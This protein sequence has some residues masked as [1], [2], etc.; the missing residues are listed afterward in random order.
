MTMS[1]LM[2]SSLLA[3]LGAGCSCDRRNDA[4]PPPMQ[5]DSSDIAAGAVLVLGDIEGEVWRVDATGAKHLAVAGNLHRGDL[6]TAGNNGRALVRLSDGRELLIAPGTRLRVGESSKDGVTVELENGTIVS[7][8]PTGRDN[9]SGVSLSVLTPFGITRIPAS[10]GRVDVSLGRESV[11]MT[12]ELGGVTFVDRTGRELLAKAGDRIEVTVGGAQLL[13]A[14]GI[15][16]V[17]TINETNTRLLPD[18]P[19]SDI[20]LPTSRKLRIY[21]DRVGEVTLTWPPA[22]SQAHIEVSR[23]PEG[24]DVIMSGRTRVP[25]VT[26]NAPRGGDLYWRITGGDANKVL[27]GHARFR[28]DRGRSVLDLAHPQ[29]VVTERSEGTK[30]YYQGARPALTFAF[31]KQD[32]ARRYRVRVFRAGALAEPLFEKEVE[33]GA[34]ELRCPMPPGLLDEGSYLWHAQGI[35]AAGRAF[36]GR[37]N[38]LELVYENALTTLA[39]GR[40]RSGDVVVGDEVSVSGIAPLGDKLFVN[41][42]PAPTDGKGRFDLRVGKAPTVVFK[43]VSRDGTESYWV[44]RLRMGS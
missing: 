10:A 40:P 7:R 21:A 19:A 38:K 24:K 20:V 14:Q 1:S 23:D 39:I 37:L 33:K 36:G 34:S 18:R 15:D 16:D 4:D 13:P 5:S 30:V 3:G 29:N 31:A 2:L 12:V 43:L 44:R 27:R 28:L 8:T 11:S 6:V 42:Q 25:R 41:G 35:D 32:G 26:L 9:T 22:L 17:E